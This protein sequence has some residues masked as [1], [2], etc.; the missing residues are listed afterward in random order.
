MQFNLIENILKYISF[1]LKSGAVLCD[2]EEMC[3]ILRAV[4]HYN[5]SNYVV[6]IY[7]K[8]AI[9]IPD[10]HVEEPHHW[11]PAHK[12]NLAAS[13]VFP[14]PIAKML[15]VAAV[16]GNTVVWPIAKENVIPTDW[17]A[18]TAPSTRPI[19]ALRAREQSAKEN[20][21]RVASFC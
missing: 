8:R 15:P 10:F 3:R 6:S 16:I 7:S 4:F 5:I 11:L 17:R 12:V 14:T 2:F 20:F 13:P 19:C 9:L 18:Q 21:G 1:T